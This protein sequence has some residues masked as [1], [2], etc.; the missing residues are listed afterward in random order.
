[1][2]RLREV[3]VGDPPFLHRKGDTWYHVTG[4]RPRTWTRLGRN[5]AVAI[6]KC[7]AI[8][9]DNLTAEELYWANVDAEM[10]AILHRN[11]DVPDGILAMGEGKDS[12]YRKLLTE[13]RALMRKVGARE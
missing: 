3:N 6:Q 7:E 13:L 12:N 9:A 2:G 8:E 4:T 1:M 10:R 11:S 5:K